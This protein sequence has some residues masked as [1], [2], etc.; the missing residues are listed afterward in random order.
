MVRPVVGLACNA[1]VRDHYLA[2]ADLARLAA[3][4]D[5]ATGE[6][7]SPATVADPPPYDQRAEVELAR[8]AS[9]LDGLVVC[10]GAPRVTE[11]VLAAAPRLRVVGDL[12]G[13]RFGGRIDVGAASAR[14]VQV[15][16]T[17]H[18]SSI[19]VAEWAL[20]LSI[21][22][23]RDAGRRFRELVAGASQAEVDST[24]SGL[25]RELAGRQVGLV[26]FGHAAWQLCE[27]LAPF[28][29]EV[30]AHDPYAPRELADALGVTFAPLEVVLGGSD[31]VVCLAPLTSRTRGLLGRHELDLLRPGSVLVNVSRGAV[32]DSAA[33]VAR[34]RRGDVVA[35]LDVYDPEPIPVD[36]PVRRLPHV[37]LSPHIAGTTAE[38]R[39]RFFQLMVDELE[40]AFGGAEPRALLTSRIVSA[41][42]GGAPTPD[43]SVYGGAT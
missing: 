26:G 39:T 34:L 20:A 18:G 10:H 19:P 36:D 12:E 27:L 16:D 42:H 38:S 25:P 22:G 9:D 40:R 28:G 30:V 8:F 5:V 13:D 35:C 1:F 32:V 23:L 15:V 21:M 17:T 33:L 14:G 43:G 4:A 2:A 29:V 41:R 3:F 11:A 31:V 24:G 7:D 37:F 6:F